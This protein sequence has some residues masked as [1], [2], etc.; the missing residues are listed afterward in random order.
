MIGRYWIRLINPGQERTPHGLLF[1]D[2]L[3]TAGQQI[4]IKA[5]LTVAHEYRD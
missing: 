3:I 1:H 4:I 2:L 5:L